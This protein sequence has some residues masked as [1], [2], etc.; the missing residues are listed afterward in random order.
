M[1]GRLT[2]DLYTQ[3]IITS[4]LQMRKLRL[5]PHSWLLP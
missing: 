4:I 5:R 1:V 3:G 2:V